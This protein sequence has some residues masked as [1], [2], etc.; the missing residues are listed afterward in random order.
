M[1]ENC[2]F[3][4]K[5]IFLSK[6][7]L[8]VPTAYFHRTTESQ[9]PT[10]PATTNMFLPFRVI[11]AQPWNY[12]NGTGILWAFRFCTVF[13]AAVSN[14]VYGL[15]TCFYIA[16]F[17]IRGYFFICNAYYKTL[18]VLPSELPMNYN[19]YQPKN[20]QKPPKY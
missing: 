16:T 14:K 1:D 8:A 12:G 6:S 18:Y 17:V 20:L 19:F 7:A 10:P 2:R 15:H 4:N 5:S 13:K 3:F 9:A 11:L